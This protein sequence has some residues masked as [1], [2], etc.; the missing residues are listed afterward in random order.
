M[1][2]RSTIWGTQARAARAL[3][4]GLLALGAGA[5]PASASPWTPVATEPAASPR[6]VGGTVLTDNSTAPYTVAIQTQFADG[7]FGGCSG[8]VIS[9]QHVLTAAHCFVRDGVVAAPQN[10]RVGVGHHEIVSPQGRAAVTVLPVATLRI[11]PL[12]TSRTFTDDVAVMTLPVPLD[13]A[14]VRVVP[15]P[16][17]PAGKVLSGNTRVRVTGFGAS[18]ATANDFGTLR[19]VNTRSQFSSLCGTD[20]PAVMLC[21]FRSGHA[22]CEGD[23]GGT[24]TIDRGTRLIG[25]TNTAVR[26]CAAGLNLFAN[27]AAPEIRTFIDAAVAEVTLTPEQI[28]VAPRGGRKVRVSGTVRPGRT[29][30]CLRGKWNGS[31]NRYRYRFLRFKGDRAQATAN[32]RKRTYRLRSGDRGWR[33]GCAVEASN[34]GGSGIALGRTLRR[35]G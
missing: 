7:T 19:S 9:P 5:P 20:A 33:I 6:I 10:V 16:L 35:V 2:H 18:S 3:I 28:P 31:K 34:D 13:F 26:D 11:H 8:T 21:T 27:V 12:Y 22:A 1:P 30:T 24:A 17:A 14:T 23:S 32:S 29:V 15:L 4:V 25:V